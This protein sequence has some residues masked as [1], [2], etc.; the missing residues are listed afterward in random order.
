[1]LTVARASFFCFIYY[2]CASSKHLQTRRFLDTL[3]GY[4]YDM[5]RILI[6]LHKEA[7]QRPEPFVDHAGILRDS[8]T[9]RPIH[10]VLKEGEDGEDDGVDNMRS[11]SLSFYSLPLFPFFVE[12]LILTCF[13]GRA[14][15]YSFFDSYDVALLGRGRKRAAHYKV[16]E[17]LPRFVP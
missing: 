3:K 15:G 10:G 9:G 4:L 6:A 14:A 2:R 5:Q 7:N 1:M 11:S 13:F 12:C 16:G 8:K 17:Y